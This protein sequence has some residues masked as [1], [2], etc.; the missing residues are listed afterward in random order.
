MDKRNLHLKLQEYCDCYMETD[1]KKGLEAIS[2]GGKDSDVTGD[3][4]EV[5]LKFIGLAILYGMRENAKSLSV[6]K[7]DQGEVQFN[8]EAA[9]KYKLPPPP[10][11]VDD[12]VFE[13]MRCITHLEAERASEPLSVGLRNDRI[14]LAVA[15]DSEGGKRAMTISFPEI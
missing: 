14:E 7:T 2:L 11:P 1:P 12:R 6:V 5:A 4:E 10:P 8:I 9:G 15:F 3:P 13:V